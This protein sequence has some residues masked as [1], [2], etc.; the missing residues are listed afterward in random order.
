MADISK[1]S[2]RSGRII[3]EDGK[4][5]N[6]V[7]LLRGTV[8]VSDKVVNIAKLAAESGRLIGEDGKIYNEVDLLNALNNKMDNIEGEVIELSKLKNWLGETTTP[9]TVNS[10]TNPI[11]ISGVSVMATAGDVT[12]YDNGTTKDEFI[13]S[14][15]GTW[16]VYDDKLDVYTKDETDELLD[17]KMPNT[18]NT[19][20]GSTYISRDFITTEGT[21]EN[22]VKGKRVVI[23]AYDES[24]EGDGELIISAGNGLFDAGIEV[25]ESGV[26][27]VLAGGV[28]DE[29]HDT[30][31]AQ[32]GQ[33]Y[34]MSGK[35]WH[36][37]KE[38]ESKSSNTE[39]ARK[40]DLTEK[41][42][43]TGG[44]V[45]GAVKTTKSTFTDNDEFVSK[46]YVDTHGITDYTQLTNKPSINNVTL[47]GNK[48]LSDLGI[49]SGSAGVTVLYNNPTPT[50]NPQTAALSQPYTDF[51]FIYITWKLLSGSYNPITLVLRPEDIPAYGVNDTIPIDFSG[52]DGYIK[53]P[54]A[55]SIELTQQPSGWSYVL[56]NVIG[57]NLGG[58][59]GRT[60]ESLYHGTSLAN[61]ITLDHDYT[62]YDEI[63]IVSNTGVQVNSV[64]Y[65]VDD[66]SV[67]NLIGIWT[68]AGYIGY[69]VTSGTVLTLSGSANIDY[70]AD[71][72]GIKYDSDYITIDS[73]MSATSEN[74]VQNKVVRQFVLDAIAAITDY[75]TEVFPNA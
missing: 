34:A 73:E 18:G 37:V 67:N 60:V 36:L 72:Y 50:V 53:F 66:V 10:T 2:P 43:K 41:L 3:G 55:T 23:R 47:S 15:A 40:G 63:I 4:I 25:D 74:P 57:I 48:T 12:A 70:I 33:L 20:T 1:L 19:K 21:L 16:Q 68:N 26:I 6:R 17:E 46:S 5:Y 49:I 54:T 52:N 32:D 9:I 29:E 38:G 30:V 71:I 31:T 27:T 69:T 28:Y 39:I 62:N 42:D 64:T 11:T 65:N 45:T 22:N 51:D 56:I 14:E 61:S 44:T 75:E 35:T 13:F 7:S 59:M 24:G 8:P 58:A